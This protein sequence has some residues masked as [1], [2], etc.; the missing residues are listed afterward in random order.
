MKKKFLTSLT[1]LLLVFGVTGFANAVFIDF[2]GGTVFYGDG[3]S[4]ETDDMATYY[5]VDYYVEDGFK[6]DFV[7]ADTGIIGDFYRGQDSVLH[8]HWDGGS[9]SSIEVSML[10]GSLFDLNTMALTSNTEWG[11]MASTGN[12]ST[13]LTA[14]N[15]SA[16]LLPSS[17][18]GID[19]LMDGSP[20]DGVENVLFGNSYNGISS[21]TITSDNGY[22][23]GIGNFEAEAPVP[24]PAT[25]VLF[26]IGLAGL[27]GAGV[28][29]KMKIKGV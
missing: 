6:I 12:E 14:S 20:G 5:G 28:R 23:F 11:G 29:R 1:V 27:F 10:D 19:Y 21:F 17:D 25:V 3:T 26:S 7:G 24:E 9:L 22:C 16:M 4:A 8:A 2:Y 15:G 18:W 13:F